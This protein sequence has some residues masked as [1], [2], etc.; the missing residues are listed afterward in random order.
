MCALLA[1]PACMSQLVETS[2]ARRSTVPGVEWIDYGKGE[3]KYA[4]D[5]WGWVTGLRRRAALRRMKRFCKGRGYRIVKEFM[6]EEMAVPY[7]SSDV[8][9]DM[10]KGVTHYKVH[11]FQ[12]VAFEC[13]APPKD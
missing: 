6:K 3:F 11:P 5:S 8:S 4:L 10:A 1:L 2:P 9:Q 12:H 7:A 13:A